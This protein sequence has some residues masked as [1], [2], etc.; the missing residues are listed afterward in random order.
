MLEEKNAQMFEMVLQDVM[1]DTCRGVG[2]ANVRDI[3]RTGGEVNIVPLQGAE[4]MDWAALLE[5][6]AAAVVI[7]SQAFVAARNFLDRNRN[8]QPA[9]IIASVR[10][11]LPADIASRLDAPT[12]ERL[13]SSLIKR[14]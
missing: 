12:V 2:R 11:T 6:L 14:L 3:I 9:E 4:R 8:K 13:L 1:P 5:K 7:L 10:L